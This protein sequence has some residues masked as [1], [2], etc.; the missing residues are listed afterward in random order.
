MRGNYYLDIETVPLEPY[1]GK[2]RWSDDPSKSKIIT[3][4]FQRLDWKTGKPL[5]K[6]TILKEWEV[7]SS[8]KIIVEQ[9]RKIYNVDDKWDFIPVGNNL[10]YEYRFL[11]C[12]FAQYCGLTG[13]KLSERPDLDIKPALVIHNRGNFKGSTEAIGKIGMS[14]Y[15][16]E[17]YDKRE[18]N[19][20]ENYI[21]DEAERFVKAYHRLK[22]VIPE[23]RFD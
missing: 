10:A 18:F 7:G 22:M 12:K 6:L 17:W 19:S 1:D 14:K 5:E 9:F 15:I 4:Q 16:P 11:E 8:E 21:L 2:N 3:I 20:I 23:I 13:L